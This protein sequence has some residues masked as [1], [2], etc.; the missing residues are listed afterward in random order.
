[1]EIRYYITSFEMDA[2]SILPKVRGHWGIESSVH[3]VLDMNF[4][5]DQ[6]TIRKGP[7]PVNIAVIKHFALSFLNN[8]KPFFKRTSIQRL[9]RMAGWR[10]DVLQSI[11][12]ANF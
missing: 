9:M 11:L 5:D 4:G 3:W 1:M 12:E 2:Q 7:A 8:A 10:N 6:C